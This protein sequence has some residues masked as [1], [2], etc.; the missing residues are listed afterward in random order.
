MVTAESPDTLLEAKRC[1]PNELD[2]HVLLKA[3]GLILE[4]GNRVVPNLIPNGLGRR[5]DNR[6]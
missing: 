3:Q 5:L 4:P 6:S 2:P 1:L